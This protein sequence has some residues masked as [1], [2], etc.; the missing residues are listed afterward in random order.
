V[1]AATLWG[2]PDYSVWGALKEHFIARGI[3]GMH[4]IRPWWYYAKALPPQ[5]MPWT[6]LVPGALVLAWRRRDRTDR[7][8]LVTVMFVVL[9]FSISTEKRNLY[10]LPAFPAFAL[11]TAR[12]VGAVLG[13]E[14]AHPISR[15][16]VTIGQTILGGL[17]VLVGAAAPVAAQRV[18]EV[19]PWMAYV[20]T[21]VLVTTGLATLWAAGKQR[22]LATAVLPAAGFAGVYLF[23]AVAVFPPADAFKS[24][25]DFAGI[26]AARTAASRAAGHEIVAFDIGNLPVH[27]AFYTDGIY[28]VETKDAAI[29]ARHL[30]QKAQV[31]AVVNTARL[32]E[33]PP[34]IRDRIEVVATTDASERKV[35]LITNRP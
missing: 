4:H 18:D 8:L 10:V 17:M 35:A 15:R 24:G 2:P 30:D 32:D 9:F 12:L 19:P 14:A 1:A 6:F 25:R 27:Y 22:L 20:L 3:H 34:R 13:W 11:M 5:L 26:I 7:L 29:L 28:T 21:G 33:L 23:V 16:W 31:W